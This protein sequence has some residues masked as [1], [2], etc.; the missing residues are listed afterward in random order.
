MGGTINDTKFTIK[1]DGTIVRG[2]KCPK[3]GRELISDGDYCEY[4][5]TRINGNSL[6]L[7][8][9]KYDVI[10]NGIVKA[11]KKLAVVKV[12]NDITHLGLKGS[13]ELVDRA[14]KIIKVGI[15][16]DEAELLKKIMEE[17]GAE[18]VIK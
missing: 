8:K 3:C 18:V 10:L 12:V 4:C 6:F 15:P 13:K 2:R 9:E 1:D 5:G 17:A 7:E 14:P 16:L 11:S